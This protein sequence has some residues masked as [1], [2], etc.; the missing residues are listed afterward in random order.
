MALVQ[1]GARYGDSDAISAIRQAGDK[2]ERGSWA[3]QFPSVKDRM[4]HPG[5]G[6]VAVTCANGLIIHNPYV[7]RV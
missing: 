3:D 1:K 4:Q 2:I 6:N 7:K 5:N